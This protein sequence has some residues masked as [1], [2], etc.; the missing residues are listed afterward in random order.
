MQ[1][2]LLNFSGGVSGDRS[3]KDAQGP[4]KAG[5]TLAVVQYFLL[6]V[7]GAGGQLD[8][9]RHGLAQAAV[10]VLDDD[11]EET[12]VKRFS[13]YQEQTAPL[14]EHYENKGCLYTIDANGT[15]NEVADKIRKTLEGLLA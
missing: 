4:L 3:E 1:K 9:C 10:P 15:P 2:L 8:L 14:V 7:G 11:T 6:C 12:V 5:Q 13:V